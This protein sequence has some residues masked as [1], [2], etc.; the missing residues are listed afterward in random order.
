VAAS[1][2]DPN[3][4]VEL[5]KAQGDDN[6]RDFF[7]ILLSHPSSLKDA[8]QGTCDAFDRRATVCEPIVDSFV[9]RVAN[10]FFS[11]AGVWINLFTFRTRYSHLRFKPSLECLTALLKMG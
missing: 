3:R 4:Q 8:L 2:Q 6:P 5:A 11:D 1:F 10:E 7:I 9:N